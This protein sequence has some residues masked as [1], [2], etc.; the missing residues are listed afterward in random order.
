MAADTSAQQPS[1]S[2]PEGKWWGHSMT[3]WGAIITTLSAV[4]PTVGPAFGLNVTAELIH[5]LGENI[6]VVGQAVGGLI[7]TILTIYGRFRA[8]STIERRQITMTM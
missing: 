2:E 5:Q 4:L 7:G 8:T 6:V 1:T 3:I